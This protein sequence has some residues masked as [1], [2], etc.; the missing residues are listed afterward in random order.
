VDIGDG[1]VVRDMGGTGTR[2]CSCVRDLPPIEGHASWW[3]TETIYS[4]VVAV[5]IGD[6][7]IEVKADGEVPRDDQGRRVQRTPENAYYPAL[8][9]IE[10]PGCMTLHGEDARKFATALIAAADACD[11]RDST[12]WP[13]SKVADSS[14]RHTMARCRR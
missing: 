13:K 6:E 2:A 1:V 11:A 5:P 12:V 10:G 3:E 9:A 14:A 4:E 7:Y 8:V